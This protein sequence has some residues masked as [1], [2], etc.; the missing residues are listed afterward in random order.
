MRQRLR[1][2]QS[3]Q[4]DEYLKTCLK[5]RGG[6][7]SASVCA[8]PNACVPVSC[9]CGRLSNI[10]F[11]SAGGQYT[12]YMDNQVCIC[13][14]LD[15]RLSEDSLLHLFAVFQDIVRVHVLTYQYFVCEHSLLHSHK[16]LNL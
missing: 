13:M 8:S 16:M 3:S 14:C 5:E 11:V 1:H 4:S 2:S 15:V 7:G 12:I 10:T 6:G 9:V